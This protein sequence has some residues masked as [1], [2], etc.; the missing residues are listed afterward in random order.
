MGPVDLFELVPV[1]LEGRQVFFNS[2]KEFDKAMSEEREQGEEEENAPSSKMHG[3]FTISGD[4]SSLSYDEIM[5]RLVHFVLDT[6][7]FEKEPDP[8]FAHEV[9]ITYERTKAILSLHSP[10][11]R[12]KIVEE[13]LLKWHLSVPKVSEKITKIVGEDTPGLLMLSARSA[14]IV[15]VQQKKS[16][17]NV[18]SFTL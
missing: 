17:L 14:A 9:L 7:K 16:V 3:H 11:K 5:M 8:R 15:M 2:I 13:L 6:I 10:E 1:G 4:I 12:K 18:G